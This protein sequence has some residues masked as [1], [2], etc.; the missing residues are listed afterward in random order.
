MSL[1]RLVYSSR[2]AVDLNDDE[3]HG[4]LGPGRV[5]NEKAGVTGQLIHLVSDDFTFAAFIQVLEGPA[6]AVG[7]T[8]T[9]IARD[10]L[11]HSL[12]TLAD[13]PISTRS[14]PGW[15]MATH[16]LPVND[17]SEAVP[18]AQQDALDALLHDRDTAEALLAR[19]LPGT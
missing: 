16:R 12:T 3:L 6:D 14:C 1:R 5:L 4:L 8:Y 19:F 7:R 9:R 13:E 18:G 10:E 2:A 15:S 17:A 11:H